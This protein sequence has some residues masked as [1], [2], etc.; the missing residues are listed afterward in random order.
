MVKPTKFLQALLDEWHTKN[1]LLAIID[2][3]AQADQT[4]E[5]LHSAGWN[6]EEIRLFHGEEA[7]EEAEE[8][9]EQVE[10][11][12]SLAQRFSTIARDLSSNESGLAEHYE[13]EAQQGH[14]ILA[15]YNPSREQENCAQDILEKHQAHHV[16]C[17]SRWNITDVRSEEEL[18][19]EAT[20]Y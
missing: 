9:A 14:A 4:V 16:E 5:A 12:Q 18:T 8:H 3:R 11:K 17:F 15:V 6:D 19:K 10:A 13:E 2:D 1:F 7:V 20:N